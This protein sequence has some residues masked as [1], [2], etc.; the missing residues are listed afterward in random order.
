MA[1]CDRFLISRRGQVSGQGAHSR[2]TASR[3]LI[4]EMR[5]GNTR[6]SGLLGKYTRSVKLLQELRGKAFRSK[7]QGK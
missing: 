7:T 1:K 3:K 5:W 6:V 4:W 2:L